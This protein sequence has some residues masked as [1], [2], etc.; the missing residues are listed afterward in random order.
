MER[1]KGESVVRLAT[2]L[3]LAALL[4]GCADDHGQA[5]RAGAESGRTQFENYCAG[6]H[7][8]D[9][10]GT[11]EGAPPLV[12]SPWVVGPE[13]RLIRIAL[14]G[15]RG[16]IEV[17][18]KTYNLEMP[19]FAPVLTDAQIAALLSFVRKHCGGSSAAITP[20]TVNAVRARDSDRT[21]YWTVEELLQE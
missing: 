11:E 18:G 5:S 9:G 13:T 10:M 4:V 17:G 1:T 6:C 3:I 19:G 21:R 15:L 14:H 7:Q 12:G 20:S 2:S 8:V 16:P